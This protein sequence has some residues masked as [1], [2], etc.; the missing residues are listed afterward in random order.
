MN[1]VPSEY[2]E[3]LTEVKKTGDVFVLRYDE[4]HNR[5]LVLGEYSRLIK[6]YETWL[7]DERHSLKYRHIT[8]EQIKQL[9]DHINNESSWLSLKMKEHAVSLKST[10]P[11]FLTEI[12]SKRLEK[13]K[14]VFEKIK[15][16]PKSAKKNKDY[17]KTEQ[18]R[19]SENKPD[20]KNE[21][22]NN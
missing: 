5:P 17:E 6:R 19:D 13:S 12:I 14:T 3:R 21:T 1:K 8:D 2:L 20:Y 16:T 9:R 10:M 11:P 4:W 7:I 22:E 15:N 18:K